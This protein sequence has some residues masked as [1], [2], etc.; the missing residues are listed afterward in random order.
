V[1]SYA[2]GLTGVWYWGPTP[3]ALRLRESGGLELR[4][5]KGGRASGFDRTGG[6]TWIGGDG[7]WDGETLRTVHVGDRLDHLDVGGFVMTREPYDAEA[8]IPGGVD[9]GGWRA[10]PDAAV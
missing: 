6:R 3:Y 4:P 10:A 5:V 1:D 7:N 2:L 8:D 9:P